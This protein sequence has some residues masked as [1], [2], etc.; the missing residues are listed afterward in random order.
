MTCSGTR[1]AELALRMKYAG[2]AA[3]R[4]TVVTRWRRGWTR[5]SPP[6]RA[7]SS[8]C[9]PTRRCWSCGTCWRAPRPGAGPLGDER[10]PSCGTTSMRR[11]PADLAL[12]L[13]LAAAQGGPVLDVGA[14]TGRVALAL[15]RAGHDVTALDREPELLD[16]LAAGGRPVTVRARRRRREPTSPST[17]ASRSS[18]CRCRRSSCCPSAARFLAVA[19]GHLAG[20]AAGGAI[21]AALEAFDDRRRRCPT[22][23][24]APSA[25]GASPRSRP[26]C[27]RARRRPI[28][29]VRRTFGPDGGVREEIDAIELAN[30]TSTRS[31]HEGRAAGLR[32]SRRGWRR[33]T[34]TSAPRW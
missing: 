13:E 20:R 22:P 1:A 14:G 24:P 32:R 27:A 12:W 11:Y 33:P 16:A 15:A 2:V 8:R 21:A 6:V 25:A 18:S 29:R 4:L 23:T 10:L 3:E 34:S 19:R 7:R 26:R 31:R 9:R 28:E 5:R 17:D 30:V